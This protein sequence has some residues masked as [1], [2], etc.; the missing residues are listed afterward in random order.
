MPQN[1]IECDRE[2]LLLMSPS[3]REWLPENHLAWFVIDAVKDIDLSPFYA[4]YREDGWGRAAHDPAMMVARVLYAYA[5]GQRAS[6][7]IDPACVEDVP[8]RVI[9]ANR[10][11]DHV[12]L[13]RCRA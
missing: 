9:A 7:G 6:R 5:K 13:N 12:P 3:L 11:P 10:A 4:R 8:Y 2:Q 1:F